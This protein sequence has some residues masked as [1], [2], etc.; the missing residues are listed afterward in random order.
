M[1]GGGVYKLVDSIMGR[2][3]LSNLIMGGGGK[4]YFRATCPHK[5]NVIALR[6]ILLHH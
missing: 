2:G 3:W 4:N 1:R 6:Q 5:I